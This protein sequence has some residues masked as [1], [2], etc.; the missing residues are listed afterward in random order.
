MPIPYWNEKQK[1]WQLNIQKN[2]K[3]KTF[4]SSKPRDKEK[5][6]M[7]EC[8]RKAAIWL[9]GNA[10]LSRI[11]FDRA[12]EAYIASLDEMVS[13]ATINQRKVY[14]ELYL[15]PRLGLKKMSAITDQDWQ[16][17]I[18]YAWRT[19]S[20]RTG[21][22]LSKKTLANIRAVIANFWK[23]AKR[24]QMIDHIPDALV[25]PKTAV[26][27]P[28]RIL[29]HDTLNILFMPSDAFYI[30]LW[31]FEAVTGLRPGE[32]MGLQFDDEKD[33]ML[34]VNRSITV[35]SIESS[36]KNENALRTIKLHM[37]AR[38]IL[39]E[40][41]AMLFSKGIKSKWI[42][43]NKWGD[44]PVASGVRS[45]WDRYRA[46]NGIDC[47]MYGLRHSFIS[48][49]KVEMPL[50][51]MKRVVGHSD[52]MDTLGTYGH[53]VDGELEQAAAILDSLFSRIINT[54]N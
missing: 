9:Q 29:Q 46:K 1:R 45:A 39:T 13:E 50:A 15:V 34:T 35:D 6:G 7:A 51:L 33:G 22:K 18:A 16:D 5:A 48:L 11:R 36:G 49:A 37:I 8:R 40:Q 54:R 43:P 10:D 30:N 47:T 41:S 3:R 38:E 24:S 44:A 21:R 31:R 14:G 52:G 28:Q 26:K 27:L 53:D 23:F 42:F 32:A 12:F 4:T 17:L 20:E 25:L 2:S 19:Q